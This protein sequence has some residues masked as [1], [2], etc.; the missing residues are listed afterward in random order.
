MKIYFNCKNFS[1]FLDVQHKRQKK[2]SKENY[3]DQDD[4]CQWCSN[5]H[6]YQSYWMIAKIKIK[7]EKKN[8]AKS[9]LSEFELLKI[10]NEIIK[11]FFKKWMQSIKSILNLA[12][13][14][15]YFWLST[16][17]PI[18]SGKFSN[19]PNWGNRKFQF[20]FWFKKLQ[21]KL[22]EILISLKCYCFEAKGILKVD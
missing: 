21:Q 2:E 12:E 8:V 13:W 3:S 7:I 9:N 22:F 6:H 10:K 14:N 1:F 20:V 16:I 19:K 4:E 11:L 15:Q 17:E 18:M 5:I